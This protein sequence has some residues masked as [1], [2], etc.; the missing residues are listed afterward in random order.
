MCKFSDNFNGDF[1]N[2]RFLLLN[3]RRSYRIESVI[4]LSNSQAQL[5]EEFACLRISSYFIYDFYVLRYHQAGFSP[6]PDECI[7]RLPPLL[8]LKS[9]LILSS[10]ICQGSP[11]WLTFFS[12]PTNTPCA[13]R[14]SA[15]C[16]SHQHHLPL[17]LHPNLCLVIFVFIYPVM[18]LFV[19]SCTYL[20]LKIH[21]QL[22]LIYP[23]T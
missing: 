3:S 10:R 12:F 7:P 4:S 11:I 9:I 23:V 13:F 2:C 20:L 17:S 5:P 14:F 18:C 1:P 15:C 21:T 16:V 6:E 22:L 19:Y 8:S